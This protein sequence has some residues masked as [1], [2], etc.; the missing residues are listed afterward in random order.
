MYN[1]FLLTSK[2]YIRTCLIIDPTWLFEVAPSY[3]DMDELPDGETRRKL[4]R[5]QMR[6]TK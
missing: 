5:I 4:E 6:Y 1:E 2:N 3:Y